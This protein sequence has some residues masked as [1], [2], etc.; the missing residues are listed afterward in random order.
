M[1]INN[2]DLTKYLNPKQAEAADIIDGPVIVF[3]GAG[4]GKTRTL[5]YRIANMVAKGIDANHILAI[6]FTNKATN[7]M[8]ERLNKLVG[9]N[10]KFLTISTF[11]ALCAKILRRDISVLGYE[12]DFEI[13]DEED[14]LKVVS[15]AIENLNV[16][17]KKFSP[18]HMRKVINTCKCFEMKCDFPLEQK[19]FDEYERIMK[20]DN[21]LDFEDLLIKTYELFANNEDILEKYQYYYQYVLVDEFQDTNLIQYKI[22]KLL[23][24]N[25]R[26]LFV[27]GDDDQSIYAFRGTNY[28]NVKLFKKDFPEF[29]QVLLE[30]NYRSTQVILDG[31]NNLIANNKDRESKIL[32]SNI[33]G[34]ASDVIINQAYDEHDEVSYVLEKVKELHRKENIPY[35]EFAILYRNSAVSRNFELSLVQSGLPYRIFGGISYLRRKEIKD[36]IAYLKLIINHNDINQFKRIVNVPSRGIGAKTIDKI[37]E[38]KRENKISLFDAIKELE[39]SLK[40]KYVVLKKFMEVIEELNHKLDEIPFSELFDLLIE[41]T[42]FLESIKDD[43]DEKERQENIDEFKSLLINIEDNGE[44]VSRREKLVNAFDEAILSDDKLQNQRQR[45]DG[46]TL[47]TV[48]SVKGLEFEC[49]FIV[50]FEEGVFP[51]DLFFDDVDLEE[52]RRIAYVAC[53]RAKSHLF[54]TCTKKRMLYGRTNH[55]PQSRFLL[56]FIGSKDIN[57]S[58]K[59]KDYDNISPYDFEV[60]QI[61]D[62]DIFFDDIR[63][64]EKK[65]IKKEV[66]E[67]E[68]TDTA[69]YKVGDFVNHKIYGDGIIVSL[70][71]KDGNIQGKICFVGEGSIKTFDMSHPSIRKRNK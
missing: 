15:Q 11:H 57:F 41:K 60:S 70:E 14:Q 54:I 66:E 28:E 31:A 25:S 32:Y 42:N 13:I 40:N 39:D 53:T 22:A 17:K 51:N 43:E 3:A 68:K 47:S 27:V 19:I 49:V 48:H 71:E 50:G 33:K 69:S 6:T 38:Y 37:I 5:T 58:S 29:K 2:I 64:E 30:E 18:K 26:N 44:L 59:K 10:A 61:R 7:E 55:N 35:K 20:E 45:N 52:E 12:R 16:D 34:K 23:T 62:D 46:I 67:V 24:K 1:S 36:L 63:E 9:P 65:E 4:T 8:K 56:E 21:R